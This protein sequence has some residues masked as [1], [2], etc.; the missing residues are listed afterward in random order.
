[1]EQLFFTVR[2]TAKILGISERTIYNLISRGGSK[3]TFIKPRR[4]G[5]K[6]LFH[7]DDIE[8][9]ADGLT[10]EREVLAHNQNATPAG[11]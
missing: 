5:S 7:R 9:Y 10:T 4:F 11:V 8:A 3:R 2:E 1:M 6:P